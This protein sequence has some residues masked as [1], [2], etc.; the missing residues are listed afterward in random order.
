MKII[1]LT[2]PVER[3]FRWP[4][5]RGL[6]GDF[7]KGDAFQV[8]RL[9]VVVHGFTH[10]D[11][12]RHMVPQGPTTSEVGLERVVGEAAVVDLSGI[13]ENTAIGPELLAAHGGHIRP[14]D[15]VLLV[16]GGAGLYSVVMPSWAAGAHTNP[17]VHNEIMIDQ[18]CEL[19]TR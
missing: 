7:A 1:D 12:P 5:E 8:T 10:I 4:V 13:A 6:R 15:I 9:D 17:I 16:A 3:H 18:F 19:P 2:M 14:D 11:S